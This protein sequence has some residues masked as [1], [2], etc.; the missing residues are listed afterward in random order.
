V[1]WRISHREFLRVSVSCEIV[2]SFFP[3]PSG[4][5]R[6]LTDQFNEEK[7]GGVSVTLREMPTNS[8]QCFD[9]LNIEFQ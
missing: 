6:T 8:G 2:F 7:E 5:V 4:S 3:D 9:H 1:V